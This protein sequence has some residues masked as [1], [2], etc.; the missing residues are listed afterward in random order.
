MR[1]V[2]LDTTAASAWSSSART[3]LPGVESGSNWSLA[4]TSA[5]LVSV[6]PASTVAVICRVAEAPLA[7]VPTV[8]SPAVASYAPAP[9]SLT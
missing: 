3:P 4:M 8:H 2:A 6:P 9:L 7:S 1:P 5:T